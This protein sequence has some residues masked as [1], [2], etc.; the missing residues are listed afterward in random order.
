MVKFLYGP[1]P[2]LTRHQRQFRLFGRLKAAL[3]CLA[4]PASHPQSAS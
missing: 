4:G 1:M 3:G 2:S